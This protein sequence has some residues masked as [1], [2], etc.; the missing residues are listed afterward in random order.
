MSPTWNH[1]LPTLS[2]LDRANT[3]T[4]APPAQILHEVIHR[5]QRAEALG[6]HRF[7]VAEHHAVPGIAGSAPTLLM[8]ALAQATDTIRIGSG[9]IM[10]PS[11]Q[12]LV[13]A[14][15]IGTLEALFPSRIDIG[16][17]SSVGFTA[18]VRRALGQ[19][20]SDRFRAPEMIRDVI[21]FLNATAEI[22]AQ[23]PNHATTP[24]FVL[25][26]SGSI[27]TAAK[28][29]AGVVVGGPALIEY[30]EPHREKLAA[31]RDDFV[32]DEHRGQQPHV[33]LSLNVAVADTE[34]QARDLLL[35][36]AWAMARSRSVGAFHP[37][38]DPAE[39]RDALAHAPAR[40]R[41]RTRDHLAQGL[42][43]TPGAVAEQLTDLARFYSAD[44]VLI[45]GGIFDPDARRA[46]DE[47]LTHSPRA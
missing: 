12:P 16:L 34:S 41:E 15:Q 23:P 33:I 32:I 4:G 11:H 31:Y 37:L 42:S 43:G 28:L 9:G 5:A 29:G 10:V 39:V 19:E 35:S 47:R 1:H 27:P 20:N 40:E 30:S 22:T 7:W 13:I 26:S 14:E 17:G 38:Q 8:A 36:E 45:T 44:E 24:L 18:P 21:S 6:Y 3:R 2:I 25:A 46:I